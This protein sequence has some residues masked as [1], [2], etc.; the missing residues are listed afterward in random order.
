MVASYLDP[1]DDLPWSEKYRM[2][3]EDWCDKEA[4]ATILEDSKS[5]VM[6]QWQTE[7]GDIPVNRAEQTVKASTRWADY[8][9]HA[10]DAR[11]AANLAKIRLE[12]VRMK[13]MEYQSKEANTRTE[14]KIL[15]R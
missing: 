13:A 11:K 15:G 7:L 5:A 9:R 8:I 10:V 1:S 6:A 3:G 2:A 14:L 4:A 12:V